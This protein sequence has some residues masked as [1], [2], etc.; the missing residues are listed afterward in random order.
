MVVSLF[1]GCSSPEGKC[2]ELGL[3]TNVEKPEN[4]ITMDN[5]IG[6]SI[7][8]FTW[9]TIDCE[10]LTPIAG[11]TQSLK[12]LKGR[13]VMVI[14]HKTMN[15]PGCEAQMPYIKSACEQGKNK[16]LITLTVY[17]GDGISDVKRFVAKKGYAFIAIADS[18]DEFATCCGFPVAAPIT[19]F[20]DANGNIK[21]EKI[22]PFQNQDEIIQ[23]IDSL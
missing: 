18:K 17:R 8:N 22:G 3:I 11:K 20:I 12:D 15:C 19:I 23:I 14:F 9:D 13:P 16:G 5:R 1:T 4:V 10:T 21:S 6:C 2:P 7:P